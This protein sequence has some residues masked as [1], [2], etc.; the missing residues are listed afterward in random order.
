MARKNQY[1]IGIAADTSGLEKSISNGLVDPLEEAAEAFE[2]L[3]KAAKNADLDR[4]LDKAQKA[5]DE[6]DD[7]LDDAREKL[8]R[9]GYAARDAGDDA[10]RGFKGAEDGVKEMGEEANSTAKEAAASFNGSAEDILD[11]FQEVAANAFAG[12]GPAGALA[13]LAI[14]AGIGIAVGKFQEAEEAA[15][16]LRLKAVEY[17]QDA[18]AAGVSTDRWISSAETLI[19]RIK[20]LEES[21][22]TDFRFFWD[23]DPSKL[24][25]WIEAYET[26]GRSG[27]EVNDVLTLSAKGLTGYLDDN[28]RGLE[29]VN[30]QLRELRETGDDSDAAVV[31][32]LQLEEEAR[33]YEDVIRYTQEQKDLQEE[34]AASAER[35]K[36]AGIASAQERVAAE[37]EAASRIQSAQESVVQSALS[38]YDSMRSAAYEKATADDAAFD[39]DKWLAYVEETRALADGYKANLAAMK[40]SPAEWENFLALP[41]DARSSI[42][43]SFAASGEDGKERIRAALSDSGSTAGS[44]AAVNFDDAFKPEASVDVEVDADTAAAESA[45]DAAAEDRE[46]TIL[47]VLSGEADVRAGLSSLTNR[48]TVTIEARVDTSQASADMAAWRRNQESQTIRVRKIVTVEGEWD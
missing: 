3:E 41:E 24:E 30:E 42:A 39:V 34:S 26:L 11:A 12:F 15:E 48:R 7:E 37:E 40:L 21:K 35:M 13:G 22:T 4:E 44:E 14:A 20:E 27:D 2:D 25:A 8:K 45:L 10:K 23:E 28:R 1:E 18:V 6:L 29:K 5:T 17:A 31:R 32:R 36:D 47:A 46:A 9:L 19:E 16:A 38:A 33:A 43:A